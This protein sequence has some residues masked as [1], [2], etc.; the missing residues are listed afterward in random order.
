MLVFLIQRLGALQML[1]HRLHQPVC[2]TLNYFQKNIETVYDVDRPA[3]SS[4]HVDI[5]ADDK[6]V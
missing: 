4:L 6:Y 1:D 2:L 3:S 5:N